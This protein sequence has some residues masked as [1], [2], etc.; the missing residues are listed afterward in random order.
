MTTTWCVRYANV[1]G[2]HI[3]CNTGVGA[4]TNHV[5]ESN[6][7]LAT[8]ALE[9]Q[10]GDARLYRTAHTGSGST[11]EDLGVFRLDAQNHCTHHRQAGS[12]NC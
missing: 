3:S 1:A 11:A 4:A 2:S 10:V 8:E 6:D 7:G 12:E 5:T 9:R